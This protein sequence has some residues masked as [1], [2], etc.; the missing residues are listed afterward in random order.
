MDWLAFSRDMNPI[1]HIRDALDRI[2]RLQGPFAYLQQFEVPLVQEGKKTGSK[3]HPERDAVLECLFSCHT[4][5]LVQ[6]C[7]NENWGYFIKGGISAPKM[8]FYG[9]NCVY[10]EDN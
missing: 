8:T 3:S 9:E 10:L 6:K 7:K 2:D 1:E 5:A 4:F